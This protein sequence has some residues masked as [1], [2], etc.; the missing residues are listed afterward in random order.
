V[1]FSVTAYAP[2][3]YL[4]CYCSICRKTAGSGGYAINLGAKAATLRVEGED[5]I[6][7]FH[8]QIDGEEGRAERRFCSRCGSALWVWDPR[9]PEL[10]HPFA[11][12]I[13]SPLPEAP[14]V[15]HMMVGSK[16]SWIR[17][18]A[19]GSEKLHDDYPKQSLEDWHRTRGLLDQD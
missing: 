6:S 19:R 13:D 5:H 15:E 9:W 10:V 14:E 16:A 8:A 2:V 18:D 17:V 1:R 4:R 3:P 12:V 11:G 7:V